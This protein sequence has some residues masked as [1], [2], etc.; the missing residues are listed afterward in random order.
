MISK[1]MNISSYEVLKA[2]NTKWNFLDF[3]PGLVG[4]HCIGVDPFYL[5]KAAKIAG[6]NPEVILSGRKIN[7]SMPNFIYKHAIRN[8]KK[9]SRILILGLTFKE[10]VKDIRN[11]K[12]ALL[13]NLFSDNGYV[14]EVHDPLADKK[15][16][17]HEYGIKLK[18]PSKKYNCIIVSVA[19]SEFLKMSE[20]K[21]VELF[22]NP[23]LLINIKNI[24]NEIKLPN[25]ISKWSL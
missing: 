2:A 1:A 3:K 16:A 18:V 11:S 21:I 14:V 17:Y 5:A 20:K 23:S 6:H 4:G 13:A 22:K 10:N 25:Y 12:S 19:H 24:W 7:D 8:L 9:N 15:Q